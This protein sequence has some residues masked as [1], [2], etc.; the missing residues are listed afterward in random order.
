MTA[1]AHCWRPE[2]GLEGTTCSCR[3]AR[4]GPSATARR[5]SPARCAS[6]NPSS[7]RLV[8]S[9][10]RENRSRAASR[11]AATTVAATSG[12]CR[13]CPTPTEAAIEDRPP[14]PVFETFE[15]LNRSPLGRE[16]AGKRLLPTSASAASSATIQARKSC[17][18]PTSASGKTAWAETHTVSVTPARGEHRLFRPRGVETAPERAESM[19]VAFDVSEPSALPCGIGEAANVPG[20][21]T[22]SASAWLQVGTGTL[23]AGAETLAGDTRERRRLRPPGASWSRG[24]GAVSVAASVQSTGGARSRL[25]SEARIGESNGRS[26]E[27]VARLREEAVVWPPE[28]GAVTAW[29]HSRRVAACWVALARLPSR[30][31]VAPMLP[32]ALPSSSAPSA[33]ESSS[34]QSTDPHGLTESCPWGDLDSLFCIADAIAALAE[35]EGEPRVLTLAEP[36]GEPRELMLAS[37][38]EREDGCRHLPAAVLPLSAAE[39]G[40]DSPAVPK[41]SGLTFCWAL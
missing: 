22:S 17:L 29:A 5:S 9:T 34:D 26:V 10:D 4:A 6:P 36:E 3:L 35:P 8:A 39:R 38:W 21:H 11:A 18:C 1:L 33:S 40:S 28:L 32:L 12:R 19:P 15:P 20:T 14:G 37:C 13:P 41:P 2:V 16:E 25:R 24:A 30:L 23:T 27:C 7:L 31:D